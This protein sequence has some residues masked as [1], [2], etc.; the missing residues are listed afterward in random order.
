MLKRMENKMKKKALVITGIILI[1]AVL[2]VAMTA[3][4]RGVKP[5]VV[6]TASVIKGDLKSYL[7]TNAVIQSKNTKDY[8][9]AAQLTVKSVNV[10]VGDKVKK[11]QVMLNY[12]LYDLNSNLAQAQ[13][14]YSNAVLQK[15]ELIDQKKQVEDT[16]ANLDI[17]IKQMEASKNPT[18]KVQLQTL[19]QQRESIQPISDEK[20]ALMANSVSLAKIALDSAASKLEKYKE[21]IVADFDGVV[22]QLNAVEQSTLNPAQP[23]I[24][25]Q[26]LNNLKAVVSLGKYD[27]A[28][29]KLGQ[30][31]VLKNGNKQYQGVV[32]F[33]NPAAE[34]TV[35]AAG[36]D[37]S[38]E[39][40]I[41]IINKNPDLKVDFGVNVDILLGSSK[42]VLTIPVE[43]IKYDKDGNS[44]VFTL[45]DGKAKQVSVNLGLQSDTE[46]EV[47]SGLSLGDSVI[48]NPS[49]SIKEGTAVKNEGGK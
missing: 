21:G 27:A 2:L 34:S 15:K 45:V 16:I 20:V 38:L 46:A 44:S 48:L 6:K 23:A 4:R 9:G 17:E 22:T 43:C 25:I 26:Q 14:Q 42:N 5:E 12:D 33:I 28:K 10:K 19:K 47:V 49:I 24:V 13:L 1:A 35:S 3:G 41:D 30:E 36:Q 31:A 11:G 8:I 40:E 7:S 18:D 37:T 39:A 29:V 32:S